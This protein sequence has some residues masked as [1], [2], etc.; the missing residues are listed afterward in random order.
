MKS[1]I[2]SETETP[3]QFICTNGLIVTLKKYYAITT[4]KKIKDNYRHLYL[5]Q[6]ESDVIELLGSKE[7]KPYLLYLYSKHTKDYIHSSEVT[8]EDE[9]VLWYID[10]YSTTNFPGYIIILNIKDYTVEIIHS[11][12]ILVHMD[13]GITKGE[14]DAI[15]ILYELDPSLA[16]PIA[17]DIAKQYQ[18]I[19]V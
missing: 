14:F 7:I 12:R 5:T 2:F 3:V 16:Y 9:I 1:K 13:I 4:S 17:L 8:Y 11:D 10:D 15:N 6:D 18:P 19:E